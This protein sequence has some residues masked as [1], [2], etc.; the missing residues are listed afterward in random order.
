MDKQT[1]INIIAI[2]FSPIIAIGI[3]EL[4]RKI[5]FEK[6]KRLMVLYNLMAYRDKVD[7]DEFLSALNSL[8]LFFRDTELYGLTFELRKSFQVEDINESNMLITKI[9]KRICKLEK[10]K[11][12]SLEDIDNLFKKK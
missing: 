3:G 11:H 7:S 9:I 1:I 10:F 2:L 6:D 5:S 4:L 8:K 12:I